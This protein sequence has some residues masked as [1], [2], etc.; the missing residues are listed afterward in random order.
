MDPMRIDL[1]PLDPAA[2]PARFEA[3]VRVIMERAGPE[4]V[5]RARRVSPILLLAQWARPLAAAAA[6]LAALATGT[7]VIADRPVSGSEVATA[8]GLAEA[9]HVPAPVA[10]WVSEE[11]PPSVSDLLV[12]VVEDI[13]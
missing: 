1:T 6:A 3:M 5:R 7:L 4:L 9:L 8:A 13:R 2:D 11:R 10:D 12:A